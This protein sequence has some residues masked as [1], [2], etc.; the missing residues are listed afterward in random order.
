MIEKLQTIAMWLYDMEARIRAD[1]SL[2]IKTESMS[3]NIE[4][5]NVR[6]AVV[7]LDTALRCRH[8]ERHPMQH[9]LV[10]MSP[11]QPLDAA[12][13]IEIDSTP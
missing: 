4:L 9:T 1:K 10:D 6:K 11:T 7:K 3:I 12:T 13:R 5:H 8:N 2:P